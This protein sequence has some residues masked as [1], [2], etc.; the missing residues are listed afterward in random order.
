M[1]IIHHKAY[2]I[3]QQITL[4][5]TVQTLG[6]FDMLDT[7]L[8][9]TESDLQQTAKGSSVKNMDMKSQI[10]QQYTE[11]LYSFF[12]FMFTLT[13]GVYYTYS[14]SQKLGSTGIHPCMKFNQKP[15]RVT[16]C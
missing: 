6:T 8:I 11:K 7:E 15:S 1:N 5:C 16:L 10:V 4:I 3:K 12:F 2:G 14:V 9:I 13:L